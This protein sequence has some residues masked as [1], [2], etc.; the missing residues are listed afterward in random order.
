MI[1]DGE[2]F[3]SCI[4]LAVWA[5]GKN[6]RTLESLLGPNEELSDIQQAFIDGLQYSV[7]FVHRE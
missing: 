5:D 1:I 7:R 3:N 6:I 2:C 4:Y